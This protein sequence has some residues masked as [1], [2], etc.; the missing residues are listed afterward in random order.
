MITDPIP[1]LQRKGVVKNVATN[2]ISMLPETRAVLEN[3]YVSWNSRLAK[4]L[5]DDRFLWKDSITS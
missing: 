2:S 4:I 3:F 5:Q 1:D